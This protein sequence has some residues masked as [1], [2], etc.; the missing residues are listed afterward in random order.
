MIILL[1]TIFHCLFLHRKH[2]T[3]ISLT[4]QQIATTIAS[5]LI[6]ESLELSTNE[7][8]STLFYLRLNYNKPSTID[9]SKVFQVLL[10]RYFFGFN[11]WKLAAYHR[12][13]FS[14]LFLNFL[15]CLRVQ[16]L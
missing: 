10:R 14:V 7:P 12:Y 8:Y 1:Q 5:N 15:I 16:F 2:G 9:E 4:S 11:F 3:E 6:T 13:P